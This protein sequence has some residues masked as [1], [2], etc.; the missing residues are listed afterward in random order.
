MVNGDESC[1]RWRD[2]D[3]GSIAREMTVGPDT[4]GAAAEELEAELTPCSWAFCCPATKL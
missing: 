3:V 4:D 2:E 1:G